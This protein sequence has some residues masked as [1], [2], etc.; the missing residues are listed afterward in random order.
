M[1][2]RLGK[3]RVT[4]SKQT[5]RVSAAASVDTAITV[6]EISETGA[7]LILNLDSRNINSLPRTAAPSTW[8]D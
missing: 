1:W 8:F 3:I 4:G 7:T 2:S 5:K 6:I